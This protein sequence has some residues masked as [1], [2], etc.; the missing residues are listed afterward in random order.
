M[1]VGSAYLVTSVA[2][3]PENRGILAAWAE[4]AAQ[5]AGPA[6]LGGDFQIQK[7]VLD[8]AGYPQRI[9]ATAVAPPTGQATCI[10]AKARSQI[11]LFMV[12][13]SLCRM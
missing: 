3:S 1:L 11:D 10:T 9:G 8:K 7:P 12:G 5:F 4:V 6:L 2:M 13:Q